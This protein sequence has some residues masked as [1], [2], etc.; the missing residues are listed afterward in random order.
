MSIKIGLP[1]NRQIE[2]SAEPV[3]IGSDGMCEISFP[4]DLRVR[5]R[6]AIIRR[7]SGRWMV[8]AEGDGSVQVGSEAPARMRWLTAG[9][10]VRLTP[11]GPEVVFQPSVAPIIA[12]AGAGVSTPKVETSA[13]GSADVS[14]RKPIT[15]DQAVRLLAGAGLV[16]AVLI[17]VAVSNSPKRD[18]GVV[19]PSRPM[20]DQAENPGQPGYVGG[21]Q[22]PQGG[23]K[24]TS[25]DPVNLNGALY[26][27]M[28]KDPRQ[29]QIYQLGT[30]WASAKRTLVSSAGIVVAV[31]ELRDV[32]PNATVNSPNLKKELEIIGMTVHP[33]YR[34][35]AAEAKAA[36]Q[37]AESL[38]LELEQNKTPDQI[39]PIAEKIVAAEERRFQALERM[40]F[41]DVGILEVKD[42]LAVLLPI[43][44]GDAAIPRP[45]SSI[46][47][48]GVPFPMQSYQVDPANLTQP[49]NAKGNVQAHSQADGN[50]PAARRI[51]LKCTK[52]LASQNWSGSP[53][54]NAAR[55]VIGVYSRP[56]PPPLDPKSP[57]IPNLHDAAEIERLREFAH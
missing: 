52:D 23:Q 41:Y 39:N 51:L 10:V 40:V 22:K 20:L 1:D 16:V 47:L 46:L 55:E 30:A 24:Q 26:L 4:N 14:T 6:H 38:R 29:E 43:A 57:T 56:T 8:E 18:S 12:P 19:P 28:V 7:V 15:K 25:A 48:A 17:I 44:G 5:P 50:S 21:D 11:D 34:R 9:D 37:E 49:S 33:E 42:E 32:L 45:G 13:T 36:Q 2:T 31:E 3:R 35:A 54:L 27:V 53:I